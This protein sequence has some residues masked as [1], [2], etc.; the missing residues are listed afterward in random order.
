MQVRAIIGVIGAG[1][2]SPQAE[3]W[4]YEIGRLIAERGAVLVCGGLD[5]VMRAACRGCAEAGGETLG[6]LPGSEAQAAN[7]WVTYPIVTNMGHARNVIIAHTAQ[8]LIAV[9]GEYGT[10]SEIAV[11]LKLGRTVAALGAWPGIPGVFYVDSPRA[12]V[13]LVFQRLA[14]NEK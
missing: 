4:A 6:I 7:P 3:A 11:S 8:A 2:A 10:L 9:D 12:A 5:G 13:D 1:S 14:E